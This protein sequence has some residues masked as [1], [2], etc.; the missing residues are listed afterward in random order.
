MLLGPRLMDADELRYLD[1][2]ASISQTGPFEQS[3]AMWGFP[4]KCSGQSVAK[5]NGDLRRT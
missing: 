5:E 2:R 3:F 4:L 1:I